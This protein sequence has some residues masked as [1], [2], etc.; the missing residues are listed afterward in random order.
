MKH[1]PLDK[2]NVNGYNYKRVK[3]KYKKIR[4]NRRIYELFYNDFKFNNLV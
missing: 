1:R 3:Y 2:I 4:K